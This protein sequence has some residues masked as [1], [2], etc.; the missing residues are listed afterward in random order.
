MLIWIY[1]LWKKQPQIIQSITSKS[2]R[3]ILTILVFW[4]LAL[5]LDGFRTDFSDAWLQE[6]LL[7]IPLIIVPVY[8]LLLPRNHC[9][10]ANSWFIFVLLTT[11][12]AAVSTIHYWMNYEEINALL[13]QS[14]HVPIF[15][16]MHH[17]YFGIV[18]AVSI[19]VCLYFYQNKQQ[20]T[21]WLVCGGLLLFFMHI[22]ASRTG[23]IAFYSA[24]LVYLIAISWKARQYKWLVI[25]VMALMILPFAG[26]H[27]SG[28][29][30]NKIANSV[31]DFNAV[32][33]GEDINYKSLAMRVEAWKTS[34]NLA[35]KHAILGVGAS[36]VDRALQQQYRLDKTVLYL[37]NRVGP[38]NQFIEMTLAHG[39]LGGI[40]LMLLL[41]VAA[42]NLINQPVLLACLAV[43]GISFLLES[44]LERQQ[45]ILVF[46]L[47]LFSFIP[48]P[49][50]WKNNTQD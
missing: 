17:I 9:G 15:G 26:Y 47:F 11:A 33:T 36:E 50:K 20:P 42:K 40:L 5:I 48:L 24:T 4:I 39:I 45:G 31:E 8:A 16:N 37:E 38:H 6:L 14:K 29:F 23:I 35:M 12:V 13:L 34:K 10:Y 41:V 21:R 2:V 44:F 46:C 7:K 27:F 25:G 1:F 30:R 32:K 43:F 18:M 22:L 19:F 28:S 3:F 49:S